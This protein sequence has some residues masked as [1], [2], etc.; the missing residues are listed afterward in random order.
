MRLIA[1]F[2]LLILNAQAD[3]QSNRFAPVPAAPENAWDSDLKW[4]QRNN[5]RVMQI[6][7]PDYEATLSVPDLME[8]LERFSVNTL[9]VNGGGI[10][11][12]YPSKLDFEYINPHMQ[13]D[14]LG[15]IVSGCH[16][17]GI[18]VLTRFDFSR[19]HESI[20]EKHPDWAYL[21]PTGE[22]IRNDDMYVT[23]VNA[24]YV[25]EKC[26]E[27]IREVM[28]LYSIDGIFINMPGY[29]TRNA[30]EGVYHGID[31][32]PHDAA[33]FA[34]FS[35]GLALPQEE[36][37]NDPV[38]QKY[39]EFKA[40][41]AEDWGKRIHDTVKGMN[42]DA[43]ICTY[44]DR[45]VD[46]MRHESQSGEPPYWPYAASENVNSVTHTYPD[47]IVSN[48][49]IQQLS[50]KSRYNAAEPPET[51]IR[52]WQNL[53]NGS[54]LDMS[55]MGDFRG[56]EDQRSYPAWER[57]Y[58]FHKKYEP[59]F[60]NYTSV[61]EILVVA[62]NAWASGPQTEEA[63]GLQLMLKESHLQFD[64]IIDA[65]LGERLE[66]LKRYKTI[67]LAQTQGLDAKTIDALKAAC[68]AGA[69]VIATNTALSDHPAALLT[70]FGATAIEPEHDG[71]GWYLGIDDRSV[72]T[73][74][75]EQSLL[76]WHYNLGLYAFNDDVATLL[77]ILTPGRPG[78]PERI[79]G[80]EPSGYLA[81][82]IKRH[83][84]G[85]AALAPLAIGRNYFLRGYQQYKHIVLDLIDHLQPDARS[86]LRTDAPPR[87]EMVLQ[88]FTENTPQ[89]RRRN[90]DDGLVL[91]LVNITG[92][93][94]NTYFE[95]I[96]L[97][98]ISV[99]LRCDFNPKAVYALDAESTLNFEYKAGRVTFV[100]PH[101]ADYEGIVI[102]K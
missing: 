61:A 5:L 88:R 42:P 50:F 56:Y 30:Y 102:R 26:M 3:A 20:F 6:N 34:A 77:P 31:Q 28:T 29:A 91:H 25:Q 70:L 32:N 89:G 4:W 53:A 83:G 76:G 47:L 59:Y 22:R 41:T 23:S 55:L 18:R 21:S 37:R 7:L 14:M 1:L 2:I 39:L 95:P 12:F 78:P 8:D 57:I 17:R 54:G 9:I 27:I 74:F 90:T 64:L 58:G 71:H 86:L 94:G 51:V 81:M 43:A 46:I 44:T 62:P 85:N 19:I 48:A 36:D 87:V 84:K 67:V 38:F 60:G 49:S 96:E 65:Q 72:L 68:E 73:R 45:Y 40:Y 69:N 13:P 100:V 98:D 93:S 52:L 63:L 92:F 75:D 15:D 10:M 101:L 79:G 24:P 80:H 66:A 97:N 33:R 35:D 99:D 16:A 82:G 11:A